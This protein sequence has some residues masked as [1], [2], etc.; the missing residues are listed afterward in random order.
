[1]TSYKILNLGKCEFFSISQYARILSQYPPYSGDIEKNCSR[2]EKTCIKKPPTH[3]KF[4]KCV[5]ILG[6]IE[7]VNRQKT[8]PHAF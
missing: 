8:T 7:H 5:S 2:L 4:R 6:K 3:A 1:M